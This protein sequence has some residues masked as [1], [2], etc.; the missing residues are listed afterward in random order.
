MNLPPSRRS[1]VSAALATAPVDG[2]LRLQC[3]AHCTTVQYPPRERCG[4]CLADALIW[5]DV[6][7][8]ATLLA[9]STLSHSLEP[10]FAE[11][12]PWEVGS[13]LLDAGPVVFAHLAAPG[14]QPGV[15]LHVANARDA[16]G[17][18][19]LVAFDGEAGDLSVKLEQLGISA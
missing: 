16:S 8:E 5:Q 10:W 18:W 11:R 17:A 4:H 6:S 15:R 3:C 1:E 12:L 14:A 19:C 2:G 9:L 13:L 7:G